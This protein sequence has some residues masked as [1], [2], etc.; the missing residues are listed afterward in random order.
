[1]STPDFSNS[2]M[3]YDDPYMQ[4]LLETKIL[5]LTRNEALYLS[6]SVT[7][8]IEHDTEQGKVVQIPSR[9]LMG[10]AVVPVPIEIIEHIGLAVLLTTDPENSTQM[11]AISIPLA[12]L[13][14]LR[15]CCHSFVKV[16]N[17]AVGYNLLRKIYALILERD[18][19]ERVA[20]DKLTAGIEVIQPTENIS[21]EKPEKNE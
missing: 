11:A 6:D 18:L 16:N 20:F 1:M 10:S 7:L 8:V 15:E 17:E 21:K 4:E 13:Y 2:G 5:T 14:L 12:E 19:K 3:D 9:S